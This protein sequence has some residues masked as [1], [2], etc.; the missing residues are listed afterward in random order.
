MW[1]CTRACLFERT[2]AAFL[3][4]HSGEL[5]AFA[6]IDCDLYNGATQVLDLLRDRLTP[7]TILHFHDILSD[8]VRSHFINPSDELKALHDFL[9]K[10]PSV[11]LQLLRFQSVLLEPAVF[12]VVRV[13]L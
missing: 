4:Q 10:S 13:N 3:Q 11:R 2:L 9:S 7:G 12:R 8:L 6:N 1:S 5:L